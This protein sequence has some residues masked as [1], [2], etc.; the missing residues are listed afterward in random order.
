[1][2]SPPEDSAPSR[3]RRRKLNQ[4]LIKSAI[5]FAA[6]IVTA[7]GSAVTGIGAHLAFAPMLTWMFGYGP[8]K[9]QGTALRFSL[10]AAAAAVV[11]FLWIDLHSQH[12]GSGY[13]LGAVQEDP[14]LL[15]N[16][17]LL[18]IG[19][20]VGALAA[21]PMTPRPTSTAVLRALQAI[22]I[23][24]GV[25]TATEAA[26]ISPLT[27]SDVHYAHW[28][29][30]WQILLLGIAVGAVTQI[31][32]LAV[33]TLLVP[34]LFFFTALP[35]PLGQRPITA[36]EAVVEALMAVALAGVLPALAYTTR[37]LVDRT[38]LRSATVGGLVGGAIGGWLLTLLLERS[39]LVFFAVFA[40]FLA[41]REIARL[42]ADSHAPPPDAPD[43]AETS[44]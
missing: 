44:A 31:A 33:G 21:A 16:A 29:A 22:A 37:Q 32:R 27:R 6:A 11:T 41:A 19:G 36:A 39:I 23:V 15:V 18:V 40:M 35:Q 34:A 12:L 7:I 5:V 42:A 24:V 13:P 25:F 30:W 43:A 14:T 9:A 38:Y 10:T 1:M 8:D 28:S 17:V 20:T 26:H 3:G 2:T 4:P